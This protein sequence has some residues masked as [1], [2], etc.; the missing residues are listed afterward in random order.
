MMD[1]QIINGEMCV[2]RTLNGNDD[3]KYKKGEETGDLFI[4]FQAKKI[5]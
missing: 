2:R 4:T 5:A 3:N 1:D